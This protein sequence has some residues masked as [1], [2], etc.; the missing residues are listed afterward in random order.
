MTTRMR[1][2]TV[3]ELVLSMMEARWAS[4]VLM[5]MP[6]SSAICLLETAVDDA[7][8]NLVARAA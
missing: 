2:A 4:T 5:E 3:P 8:E 6:R 7:L 1:S